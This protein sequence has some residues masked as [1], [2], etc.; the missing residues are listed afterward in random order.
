MREWGG[1]FR[2]RLLAHQLL[3]QRHE[4]VGVESYSRV[5]FLNSHTEHKSWF[6][7]IVFTRE[8]VM[9]E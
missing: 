8:A 6:D 3:H 5:T 9:V 7:L 2:R 1:R 4:A